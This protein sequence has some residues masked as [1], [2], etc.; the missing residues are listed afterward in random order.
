LPAL[1]TANAFNQLLLP[2][3]SLHLAEGK[4]K[5]KTKKHFFF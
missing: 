2:L 5:K 3:L 4:K 1:S